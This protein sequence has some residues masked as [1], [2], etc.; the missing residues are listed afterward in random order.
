MQK[1]FSFD[2][3]Q[4]RGQPSFQPSNADSQ[5]VGVVEKHRNGNAACHDTTAGAD[6]IPEAFLFY[7]D[8]IGCPCIANGAVFCR[9]S[10]ECLEGVGLVGMAV[11]GVCLMSCSYSSV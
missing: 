4:S 10:C 6:G 9:D 2:S 1:T 7:M 5:G 11:V 3:N 8:G